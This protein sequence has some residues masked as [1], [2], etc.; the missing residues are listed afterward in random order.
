MAKLA[1]D[2]PFFFAKALKWYKRRDVQEAIVRACERREVSPRYGEGFGK[3][4]DVLYYPTDVLSFATNKATSFHCSEERWR[5]PLAIKTGA[6]RKEQDDLRVGWDLVL[7]IDCPHWR[8]AKLTAALFIRALGQ[9]GL[10]SITVKF[11]GSKGFHIGVP[12]EAFPEEHNGRPTAELFPEGPRAIAQH[13]L[14]YISNPIN[15]LIVPQDNTILFFKGSRG[16]ERLSFEEL[17]AETGKSSS[18]LIVATCRRCNAL[19]ESRDAPARQLFLCSS[20][21][22]TARQEGYSEYLVCERCNGV[23]EPQ[24]VSKD[25]K[26][27]SRCGADSF[28]PRFNVLALI[29]V[30]TVLLASRHLFRTPYSLHEK[31]GLVSVVF[32]IDGILTFEKEHAK[33][34]RVI[35]FGTFLDTLATVPG[36]G[37][38]LLTTAL[39]LLA[40]RERTEGREQKEFTVPEEAIPEELFPP[41]MQNILQGMDDGKKRA[42][43]ALTNFLRTC[44]WGH[45]QI[46]A[47]LQEW[48]KK[49][50]EPIREVILKGHLRYTRLKKEVVPPP[51][52]KSFYQDLRVCTPDAFCARIKNPAQYAKLKAENLARD[53]TGEKKRAPL[54]EEQKAMR[55]AY[56]ERVKNKQASE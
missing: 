16:E 39:E 41:C 36:E 43:F 5:D 13:L 45:D 8:Y 17:Q 55:K 35:S 20:C 11:S 56:R 50:K 30:D 48:N 22:H 31:S 9:H 51:N 53:A 7:D 15:N 26:R 40:E 24:A 32:P 28:E 2:E 23:M 47:R 25:S 21:G 44:G 38:Q 52:C 29:E 42:M 33:P 10:R 19:Q 12:F 27:C 14:Q 3:R 1:I 54:S 34:E 49:H 4:P 37:A 18:E 46:E 6:S